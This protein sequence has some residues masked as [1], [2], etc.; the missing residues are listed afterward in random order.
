MTDNPGTNAEQGDGREDYRCE[1]NSK[2][3]FMPPQN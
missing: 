3:H 2:D 1:T